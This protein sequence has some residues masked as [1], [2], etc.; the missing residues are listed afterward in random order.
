V[1]QKTSSPGWTAGRHHAAWRARGERASGAGGAHVVAVKHREGRR[2]QVL[3][4][5]GC[6][7]PPVVDEELHPPV[8]EELALDGHRALRD[9][10]AG[11]VP[12]AVVG[13]R[14]ER[15]RRVVAHREPFEMNRHAG[16]PLVV[17]GPRPAVERGLGDLPHAL[18]TDQREDAPGLRLEGVERPL[19]LL[20]HLHLELVGV[21]LDHRELAP[22]ELLALVPVGVDGAHREAHEAP[23]VERVD[24]L[25]LV[26]VDVPVEPD[27]EARV[28]EPGEVA[29]G[30]R[31]GAPVLGVEAVVPHR[32]AHQPLG[33]GPHVGRRLL[34]GRRV[35]GGAGPVAVVAHAGVEAVEGHPEVA[36]DVGAPVPGRVGGEREGRQLGGHL[37][38]VGRVEEGLRVAEALGVAAVSCAEE[39]DVPVAG[40]H[41]AVRVGVERSAPRGLEQLGEAPRVVARQLGEGALLPDVRPPLDVVV[42]RHRDEAPPPLRV[43]RRVDEREQAAVRKAWRSAYSPAP[44][45]CVRSPLSTIASK[46][47]PPSAL[48]G[49]AQASS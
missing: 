21:E 49:A 36:Q 31:V 28:H 12:V 40:L 24:G 9:G 2:D 13:R 46:R 14:R 34:D 35:D 15:D 44:A 26:A 3:P 33:V 29:H 16:D 8:G 45:R 7:A 25:H 1:W 4:V 39:L 42:A 27:A 22:D 6:E 5:E 43:R 32:D 11:L 19:R 41:H 10:R 48:L 18:L 20:E 30:D 38:A 47:R 17:D 37:D 23:L